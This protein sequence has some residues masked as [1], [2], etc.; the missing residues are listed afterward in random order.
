MMTTSPVTT[1]Q[2][3]V[4][5]IPTKNVG[6]NPLGTKTSVYRRAA[7]KNPIDEA[8]KKNLIEKTQKKNYVS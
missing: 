4:D 3:G 5:S 2:T 1:N 6:R 7:W 8:S